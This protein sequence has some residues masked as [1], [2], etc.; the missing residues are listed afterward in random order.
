LT[1]SRRSAKM[2]Y[3]F[4]ATDL[5][6]QRAIPDQEE[7]IVYEWLPIALVDAQIRSGV[8]ANG[9]LLAAWCIFKARLAR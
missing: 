5:A 2:C 6:E 4:Q 8:I 1:N 7:F 3:L 9:V